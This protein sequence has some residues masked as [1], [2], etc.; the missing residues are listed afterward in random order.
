VFMGGGA[1]SRPKKKG[2]G[3]PVGA[4]VAAEQV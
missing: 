1:L 2:R 4:G 3:L